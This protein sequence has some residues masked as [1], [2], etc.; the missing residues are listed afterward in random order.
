M[1]TGT[2]TNFEP[3][4]KSTYCL[5]VEE[6]SERAQKADASKTFFAWKLKVMNDCE[7]VNRD[8][9]ILTPTGMNPNS[10]LE[11]MWIACGQPEL[12]TGES[13]NTDDIVGCEFYAHVVVK[14]RK[15]NAGSY[16]E[17]EAIWSLEDYEKEIAKATTRR[18]A[19]S[20]QSPDEDPEE[21]VQPDLPAQ[22]PAASAPAQ[23][24][25]ASTSAVRKP[26]AFPN[27]AGGL[28]K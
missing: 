3:V 27:K 6:C 13:F 26:L 19:T 1:P 9:N 15:G 5:R 10:T 14:Q 24:P 17:L 12:P 22:R 18:P 16:N 7:E 11:K 8:V 20:V 25:V 21:R 2:K 4:P 28:N 23:R